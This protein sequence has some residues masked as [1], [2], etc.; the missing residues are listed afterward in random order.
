LI[1]ACCRRHA[2]RRRLP[3][4]PP[5]IAM[6]IARRRLRHIATIGGARAKCHA[7]K[8]RAQRHAQQ[9][10]SAATMQPARNAM[11]A[12]RARRRGARSRYGATKIARDAYEQRARGERER[13]RARRD[14]SPQHAAA[15]VDAQVMRVCAGARGRAARSAHGLRCPNHLIASRR[16]C[17]SAVA[18][19]RDARVSAGAARQRCRMLTATRDDD[20]DMRFAEA[21][22]FAQTRGA[23]ALYARRRY[24]RNMRCHDVIRAVLQARYAQPHA[25]YALAAAA[26]MRALKDDEAPLCRSGTRVSR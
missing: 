5:P 4:M 16:R 22:E 11:S 19:T 24:A 7:G 25:R 1:A 20:G 8:T 17:L 3:P 9:R 14:E 6:P 21:R 2:R 26:R 13:W 18:A 15:A 23:P 12:I 10:D